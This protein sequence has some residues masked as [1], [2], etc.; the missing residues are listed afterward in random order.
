[1]KVVP[2]KSVADI[3]VCIT[4]AYRGA[5][6]L[7]LHSLMGGAQ[8]TTLLP[9]Q[10]EVALLPGTEEAALAFAV[11]E[12]VRDKL[13]GSP[14]ELM[15]SRVSRVSCG[16][17]DGS[18]VIS[19]NCPGTVS[20]LRKT[21][22]LAVSCLNAAKLYSKFSEN[23]RYLSGKG[24]DR[25]VFDHC[26]AAMAK[27]FKAV[28]VLAVGRININ[29]AKLGAACDIV[30]KKQPAAADSHPKGTAPPKHAAA[31][32][33]P[34]I[35]CHGMEAAILA[36]YIRASSGG[37]SVAT[38]ERGVVVFNHGWPAKRR[39]LEDAK[40]IGDYTAKKYKDSPE[41]PAAFVYFMIT[42]GFMDGRGAA[43]ALGAGIS[44]EVAAREIKKAFRAA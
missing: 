18:F 4:L 43:Q 9:G 23:M 17:F 19:W 27:A 11:Y 31:D 14:L 22:G 30:A 16:S 3:T 25:G 34:P 29:A 1:M 15:K 24:G 37:M 41:L 20:S 36:D 35:K 6:A 12:T 7:C 21:A 42:Q 5:S 44:H 8:P 32:V 13:V 26:A 2:T 10:K 28:H 40:R 38:T 39:H 33:F